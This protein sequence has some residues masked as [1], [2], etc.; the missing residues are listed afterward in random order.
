MRK[1]LMALLLALILLLA[2]CGPTHIKTEAAVEDG[3]DIVVTVFPA[4][5][6]ARAAAG[7]LADVTLL[8][9]DFVLPRIEWIMEKKFGKQM[10]K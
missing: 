2:G 10:K 8:L 3:L 6:L 1:A 4:Y 5:D 7:G 9:Y